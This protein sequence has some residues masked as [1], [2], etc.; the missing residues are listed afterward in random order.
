MTASIVCPDC[1]DTCRVPVPEDACVFFHACECCGAVVRAE[2]EDCCVL[3]SHGEEAC[4]PVREARR[5]GDA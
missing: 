4:P 5:R 1:H 3:C 2:G